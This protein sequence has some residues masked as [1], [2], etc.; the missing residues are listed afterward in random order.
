M[1]D[2]SKPVSRWLVSTNWLAGKMGAPDLV[3]V[4][5]SFYLPA[6][7]RDAEAEYLASHIPGAVPFTFLSTLHP[8]GTRAC[9]WFSSLSVL[10]LL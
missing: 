10:P 2:A 4:D 6:M 3:V 5:G 7:Q 9:L 1:Q 8:S